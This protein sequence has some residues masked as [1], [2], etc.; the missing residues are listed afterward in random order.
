MVFTTEFGL[1]KQI[2]PIFR[3]DCSILL[4]IFSILAKKYIKVG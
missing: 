4:G 1:I 2:L 3:I